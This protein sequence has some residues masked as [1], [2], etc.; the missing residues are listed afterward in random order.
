M[1]VAYIIRRLEEQSLF[2][3]VGRRLGLIVCQGHIGIIKGGED[4]E[5]GFSKGFSTSFVLWV[6]TSA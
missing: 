6:F 5:T 1:G 4:T 3:D 2:L